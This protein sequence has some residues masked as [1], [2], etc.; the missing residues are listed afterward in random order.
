MSKDTVRSLDGMNE[1]FESRGIKVKREYDRVKERYD[2]SLSRD[3]C[4][5]VYHFYYPTTDDREERYSQM[6]ACCKTMLENFD[7]YCKEHSVKLPDTVEDYV[8]HGVNVSKPVIKEPKE[9]YFPWDIRAVK[10]VIFN[11]PATIV[12]W[13]DDTKTVVKCSFNDIYDPEKG[14]AMAFVKKMFGNDNSFHKLFAKWLP[15]EEENT[16]VDIKAQ[17]FA[18]KLG[19]SLRTGLTDLYKN[20]NKKGRGQ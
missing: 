4:T 17:E 7:Q 10:K 8:C 16:S 19:E 3:N 1:F 12:F 14:M 2:F 20:F 15:K 9:F 11:D 18:A 5:V 13:S 6:T